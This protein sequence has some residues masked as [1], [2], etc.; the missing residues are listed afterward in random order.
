MEAVKMLLSESNTLFDD[1]KKK[2]DDFP[3]LRKMLYEILYN[4]KNYSYV[5]DDFSV[6]IAEMFG[7]IRQENQKII[8]SNRIF[9]TRLYNLFAFEEG[10]NSEIY[11][12][13]SA[14]KNQFVKDGHL[15]MKR[16]LERFVVH[17]TDLYGNND[18]KFLEKEGRKY[19]LF[20]LKPIINGTGNYY[21]EAQTRDERRT[22]VI[23]DYHG[24]QFVIE[25][26]IWHGEEYNQ[27]GEI[28]LT[29]YLEAFHLEKGYLLSFNFNKKKEIGVKEIQIGNKSI[30]EAIV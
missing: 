23:V 25:M 15:N 20:Y 26:K 14:D 30:I 9:E 13:A 1:M 24:E 17:F 22:D 4:G 6:D 8:I 21:V 5:I 18:E 29:D 12:V 27:R 2:I 16:I 19:F 10:K 3:E 28:Q 7:Y 11:S